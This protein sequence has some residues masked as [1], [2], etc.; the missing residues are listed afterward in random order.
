MNQFRL[1]VS[2]S[3]PGWKNVYSTYSARWPTITAAAWTPEIVYPAAGQPES[4][5]VFTT[6]HP[7]EGLITWI[8]VQYE[9]ASGKIAYARVAPDSHAGL[10]S[11]RCQE[12]ADGNTSATITYT[13][14]ALGDSG[15]NYL[16]H[17]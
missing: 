16:A 15:N 1:N 5:A 10:I 2:R 7:G 13:L 8:M 3:A 17:L 6:E 12:S 4:G 11:V 9:L 14:T